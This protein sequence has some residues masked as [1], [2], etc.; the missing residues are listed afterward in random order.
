MIKESSDLAEF[1]EMARTDLSVA[2][3]TAGDTAVGV[4]P[5]VAVG[6]APDV[7][8]RVAVGVV[9]AREAVPARRADRHPVARR[10]VRARCVT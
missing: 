5:R 9:H 7:A 6:V 10:T 1:R 4:V 2:G 3:D 8:L